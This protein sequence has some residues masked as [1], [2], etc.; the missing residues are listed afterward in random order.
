MRKGQNYTMRWAISTLAA[1]LRAL[2]RHLSRIGRRVTTTRS[3][4]VV[5][6]RM[7]IFIL[8]ALQGYIMK[9]SALQR[10]FSFLILSLKMR[11]LAQMRN[12]R[13]LYTFTARRQ[14]SAQIAMPT[15]ARI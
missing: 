3:L 14:A 1:V 6:G 12:S 5:R 11:K 2:T 15:P 13:T 4:P 9:Q 10:L 8:V 7:D